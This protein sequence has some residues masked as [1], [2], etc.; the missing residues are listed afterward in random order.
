[1]TLRGA[2]RSF[3]PRGQMARGGRILGLSEKIFCGAAPQLPINMKARG[4]LTAKVLPSPITARM[5][6]TPA[7]SV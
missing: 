3:D 7:P 4:I 1:M 6:A 5:A 2:I